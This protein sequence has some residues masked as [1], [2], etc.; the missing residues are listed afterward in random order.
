MGIIF[1]TICNIQG[2]FHYADHRGTPEAPGR[3]ATLEPC[4]EN[5]AWGAAYLLAG[6]LQQQRETLKYLEWREKQY[7]LRL[8]VNVYRPGLSSDLG[9]VPGTPSCTASPQEETVALENALVYI[10]TSDT[11]K[12]VNYLGPASEEEIAHQIAHAIGPSGPNFEYVY[13]LADAMRKMGVHDEDL[14]KM[15]A[16][17]RALRLSLC[18]DDDKAALETAQNCRTAILESPLQQN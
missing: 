11:T 3:T 7:D 2:T 5:L 15:E 18:L 14:I 16:Q 10:A 4:P 1:V 12:N 9:P 13:K 17:I 6:D 8:F